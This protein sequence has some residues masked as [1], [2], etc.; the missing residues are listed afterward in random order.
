LNR[1]NWK[2]IF[3][4]AVICWAV[5]LCGRQ[6]TPYDAGVALVVLSTVGWILFSRPAE[7]QSME[8]GIL[9]LSLLALHGLSAWLGYSFGGSAFVRPM[10]LIGMPGTIAGCLIWLKP[11]PPQA[12]KC[13]TS[14]SEETVLGN[15]APPISPCRR[16]G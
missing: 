3:V 2:V 6:I 1:Y 13:S 7:E 12:S 14:A 11:W 9:V 10:M 16:R 5:T 4:T 8:T 15:T